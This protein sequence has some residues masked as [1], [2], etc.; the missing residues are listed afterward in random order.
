[1]N[2]KDVFD[3]RVSAFAHPPSKLLQ[4]AKCAEEAGEVLGAVVKRETG[5]K[6]HIDWTEEIKKE[7]ADLLFA[8]FTVAEMEGF[9][10]LE[11]AAEKWQEV[12][13]RDYK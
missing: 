8:M 1:M 7:L 4:A 3:W 10:L 12:S 2:Q 9:D 5:V 11:N 13:Q 6:Q